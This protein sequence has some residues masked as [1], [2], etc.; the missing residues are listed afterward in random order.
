[1]KRL[2]ACALVTLAGHFANAMEAK[3][4]MAGCGVGAL[5]MGS[6]HNQVF[7]ATTNGSSFNG[8]AISSGTSK[9]DEDR[10]LTAARAQKNFFVENMKVLSKELAQGDGEYTRALAST[11][12]C[13]EPSY[14]AFGAE[15]QRSYSE[16]FAQPGAEAMLK[17][18]R[19]KVVENSELGATC[20][21]ASI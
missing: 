13:A 21:E 10:R 8:F 9:C 15:M 12:G 20:A 6:E 5:W 11:F 19:A 2:L 17:R 4:G 1:M 14:R 3:Y 7:A 16:I 18:I